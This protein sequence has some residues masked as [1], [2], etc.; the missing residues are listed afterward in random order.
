MAELAAQAELCRRCRARS[1]RIAW[2]C[3]VNRNLTCVW[4][5]WLQQCNV[6][7]IH[8]IYQQKLSQELASAD[9]NNIYVLWNRTHERDWWTQEVYVH[10]MIGVWALVIGLGVMGIKNWRT[11]ELSWLMK[12][13]QSDTWLWT[14]AYMYMDKLCCTAL[15]LLFVFQQQVFEGTS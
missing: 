12:Y 5:T 1:G 9:K 13:L 4:F 15:Y 10:T 14:L 2:L 6:L 3:K 11:E 7:H 8:K